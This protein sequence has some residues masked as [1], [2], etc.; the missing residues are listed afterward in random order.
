MQLIPPQFVGD[1]HQ[2]LHDENLD[3]GG[4]TIDV[5]YDGESTNL[6]HIWDT[7]MPEQDAGGYSLSDAQKYATLL[8]NRIKSGQYKTNSSSW[9]SGMDISDPVS[10][11]MVWASD[12]NSYVCSTVL[13]PGLG[14]IN[15]TDLSG[16]YYTDSKPVFEELIAR[17][18]Y[19]LAKWLDLIADKASS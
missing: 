15:T 1:I 18:G 12:A 16:K 17:A 4:N 13:A 10:S 8:T 6:H 3:V 11:S 19:R 2:P 9:T 7:N 5:E 14:Y